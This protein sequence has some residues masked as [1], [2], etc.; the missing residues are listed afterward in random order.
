MELIKPDLE[1]LVVLKLLLTLF[2]LF[3][4]ATKEVNSTEAYCRHMKKTFSLAVYV[5]CTY[6]I[7]AN[8]SCV[9]V[10]Y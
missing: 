2:K 4:A 3:F 10:H 9:Y 8:L 6:T 1:Q 7:S 5:S